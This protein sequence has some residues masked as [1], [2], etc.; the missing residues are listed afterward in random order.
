MFKQKKKIY[1]LEYFFLFLNNFLK[2]LCFCV[3]QKKKKLSWFIKFI[4]SLQI[5][6][7]WNNV[8]LLSR[9]YFI[10]SKNKVKICLK[11]PFWKFLTRYKTFRFQK[12]YHLGLIIF[13]L[14]SVI[15]WWI[16]FIRR[17]IYDILYSICI[18]NVSLHIVK[19]LKICFWMNYAT[20]KLI[21]LVD[22]YF[23]LFYI[24]G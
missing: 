23:K 10:Y 5:N 16:H 3:F 11:L 17:K 22:P 15:L 6:V 7:F 19:L 9:Y 2:F 8:V 21:R 4:Y 14:V 20:V 1:L 12:L 13:L 24:R 18:F